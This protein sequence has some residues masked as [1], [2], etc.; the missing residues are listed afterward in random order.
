MASIL[1]MAMRIIGQ[2]GRGDVKQRG[3]GRPRRVD[4][5]PVGAYSFAE[6]IPQVSPLPLQ[7]PSRL[8]AP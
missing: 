2:A 7:S 3:E 5:L 6:P 4:N 8:R 1:G